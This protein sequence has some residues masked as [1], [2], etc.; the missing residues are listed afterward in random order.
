MDSRLCNRDFK[1]NPVTFKLNG[2]WFAKMEMLV[3]VA[4]ENAHNIT[5][6]NFQNFPK[7]PKFREMF[8]VVG[9]GIFSSEISCTSFHV[10]EVAL[11]KA[12]EDAEKQFSSAMFCH[13]S[14]ED[15][16]GGQELDQKE[17]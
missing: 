5:S 8:D 13:K 10:T 7:G 17:N 11:S 3:T 9:D 14:C 16:K 1:E 2:P 12:M 4:N 15:C 6:A